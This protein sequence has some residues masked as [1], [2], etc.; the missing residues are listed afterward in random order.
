MRLF[1]KIKNVCIYYFTS[2]CIHLG[3]HVGAQGGKKKVSYTLKLYLYGVVSCHVWVLVAKSKCWTQNLSP[4]QEQPVVLTTDLSLS[5]QITRYRTHRNTKQLP[6]L[7][8]VALN[9][10]LYRILNCKAEALKFQ[11]NLLIGRQLQISVADVS[12]FVWGNHTGRSHVRIWH[13]IQ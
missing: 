5:P 8:C 1:S 9:T 3:T 13:N 12:S 7:T 6:V 2:M 11:R 10:Q 4:L